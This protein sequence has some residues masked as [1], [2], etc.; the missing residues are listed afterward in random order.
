M[1]EPAIV[2]SPLKDNFGEWNEV[3]DNVTLGEVA[4]R[5]VSTGSLTV[6]GRNVLDE[7]SGKAS[8]PWHKVGDP[9]EPGFISAN[10]SD[11]ARDVF[12]RKNNAGLVCINLHHISA[13]D[14]CVVFCLPDGYRPERYVMF[15]MPQTFPTSEGGAGSRC[16]ISTDGNV[17]IHRFTDQA[18]SGTCS[19][20]YYHAFF[21]AAG[22]T[23]ETIT[24]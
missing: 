1:E 19:F 9:G 21:Q 17:S 7:L 23:T 13:S 12:F 24:V 20:V 3:G 11:I 4:A 18:V 16:I 10:V 2:Y 8:D 15:S 6:G 14:S 22:E 5:S